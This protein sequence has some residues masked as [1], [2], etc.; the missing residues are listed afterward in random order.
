MIACLRSSRFMYPDGSASVH[1][2]LRRL[3][4]IDAIARG[5]STLQFVVTRRLGAAAG[6]NAVINK[7]FDTLAEA[8]RD[9][10]EK[11][12]ALEDKGMRRLDIHI[13][14]FHEES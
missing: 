10:C 5:R 2:D 3:M 6:Q 1:L 12:M 7:S 13:A 4:D 14:G 9:W 8:R 11:A